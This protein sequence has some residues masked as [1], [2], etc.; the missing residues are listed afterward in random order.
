MPSCNILLAARVSG[1]F[2]TS[3]ALFSSKGDA[4]TKRSIGTTRSTHGENVSIPILTRP[5][6]YARYYVT[7]PQSRTEYSSRA[8]AR[9]YASLKDSKT[10]RMQ[11]TYTTLW[12]HVSSPFWYSMFYFILLIACM[13]QQTSSVGII[14]SHFSSRPPA[15]Q[16]PKRSLTSILPSSI[17]SALCPFYRYMGGEAHSPLCLSH[18]WGGKKLSFFLPDAA[19]PPHN[20]CTPCRNYKKSATEYQDKRLKCPMPRKIYRKTPAKLRHKDAVKKGVSFLVFPPRTHLLPPQRGKWLYSL[21][22]CLVPTQS[23][24]CKTASTATATDQQPVE[25]GALQGKQTAEGTE[26]EFCASSVSVPSG[27]QGQFP[28]AYNGDP[29]DVLRAPWNGPAEAAPKGLLQRNKKKSFIYFDN[30]AT[31]QKPWSVLQALQRAYI[32]ENANVHRSTYSRAAAATER[33]EGVRNQL[34]KCLNAEHPE[35]IVFTSGATDSINL[36]AGSWG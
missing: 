21:L 6:P 33:L 36:V 31:T 10:R 2:S 27:V 14:F 29:S 4:A 32:H 8:E 22:R 28:F 26:K 23:R 25:Q 12:P 13:T 1:H 35:E 3:R 9:S 24:L 5:P 20:C 15:R 7:P 16:I 18:Y 11:Y 34:A 17:R 30:A 19:Q